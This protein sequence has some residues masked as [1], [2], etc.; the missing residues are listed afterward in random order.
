MKWN[1]ARVTWDD[2]AINAC[3]MP[4]SDHGPPSPTLDKFFLNFCF[5]GFM[6]VLVFLMFVLSV[7]WRHGLNPNYFSILPKNLHRLKYIA[8]QKTLK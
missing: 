2:P 1:S 5:L 7:F 4:E 8:D 6:G 3:P